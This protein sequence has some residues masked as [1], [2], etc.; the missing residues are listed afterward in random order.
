MNNQTLKQ[1][2]WPEISECVKNTN[3]Q[4]AE[5]ID[6]ES[7]HLNFYL[8]SFKY[9]DTIQIPDNCSV[10]LLLNKQAECVMNVN[11]RIVPLELKQP[12]DLISGHDAPW[13]ITA[14]VRTIYS[15]A[16]ISEKRRHFRLGKDF[17]VQTP[18]RNV[19]DHWS[20]F[21]DIASVSNWRCEVLFLGNAL[22]SGSSGIAC[23]NPQDDGQGGKATHPIVTQPFTEAV[24]HSLPP[25]VI[26]WLNHG[27]Q[28]QKNNFLRNP[29][30]R[31]CLFSK[32]QAKI[33][34]RHHPNIMSYA[35]HIIGMAA[36]IAPGL[37]FDLNETALPKILIQQAYVENYQLEYAPILMGLSKS[38]HQYFSLAAPHCADF[39]PNLKES[40]ARLEELR[41]LQYV[42]QK[43]QKTPNQ[44]CAFLSKALKATIQF[45]HQ[46][47]EKSGL[48]RTP[49]QIEKQDPALQKEIMFF[50]DKKLCL[51]SVLLN[52]LA[53]S[54]KP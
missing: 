49:D 41:E 15:T 52:G 46:T 21:R 38:D 30:L 5:Q 2:S 37:S 14:G 13:E 7:K 11:G 10:G 34:F 9:G 42:I 6:S 39:N 53:L 28:V 1:V 12:G 25:A 45:F 54:S 8:A 51:Y 4:L 19:F 29:I 36:G 40:M 35:R 27:I 44:D 16:K 26:P 31:D 17:P 22:K 43:M 18:P 32:L 50:Q 3:P 47:S 23:G 33:N 48:I 24:T 20:V